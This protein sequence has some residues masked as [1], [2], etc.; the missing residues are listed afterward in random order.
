M[1]DPLQG[2]ACPPQ[3]LCSGNP[4]PPGATAGHTGSERAQ[5]TLA[6]HP[7]GCASRRERVR[8]AAVWRTCP[9]TTF[10][11]EEL[12]TYEDRKRKKGLNYQ[13]RVR[14]R[15]LTGP[16]AATIFFEVLNYGY[17]VFVLLITHPFK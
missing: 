5:R 13:R 12:F 1:P 8:A 16:A 6:S 11:V 7:R 10:G 9:Q 3:L 2:A 4:V 14:L 15:T 17:F